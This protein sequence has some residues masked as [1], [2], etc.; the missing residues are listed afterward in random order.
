MT[1]PSH[2][3]MPEDVVGM[4]AVSPGGPAMLA[5]EATS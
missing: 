3:R 5:P 2:P 1:G 4:S